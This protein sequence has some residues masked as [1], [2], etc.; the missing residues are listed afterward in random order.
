MAHSTTAHSTTVQAEVLI[1]NAR[2]VLCMDDD[3]RELTGTDILIRDGVIATPPQTLSILPG[4]TRDSVMTIARE[5]GYEVIERSLP[6]EALYIADEVFFTG[7]AAEVT[8]VR[9]VDHY[10]VGSGSRGPITADLQSAYFEALRDT[11]NARGWLT[12][13]DD[14]QAA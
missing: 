3:T 7:T 11:A 10:T 9:S 1:R 14:V 2:T 4:I 6:R 8:P 13:V 5:R 12:F